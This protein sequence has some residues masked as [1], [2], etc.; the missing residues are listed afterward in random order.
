MLKFLAILGVS[1]PV[2][3]AQSGTVTSGGQPIPGVAIRATQGERAITTVSD[4]NGAFEFQNMTPGTWTVEADMFGF[5]HFKKDFEIGTSPVKIDISLQLGTVQI[6][7]AAPARGPGGRGEGRGGRGGQGNQANE[8]IAAPDLLAEAPPEVNPQIDSSTANDSFQIQGTI[9]NGLETNNRDFN[10]F[11]PGFP[12]G[13]D[14]GGPNGPGGPGGPNGQGGNFAQGGPGGPGGPGGGGRGGGGGRQGG[15]NF[16]GGGFGPGGGGGGGRGGGG[17]GGRGQQARGLIGNRSRQGANQIRV[18]VFDTISDSAFDAKNYSVNGQQSIKPST[19]SNR[20]GINIGG[21]FIIPH[22]VDWSKWL[23]FTVNYNG[24]IQQNATNQYST[25]P[26]S[27]EQQGNFSGINSIIYDPLSGNTTPFPGNQIP[28]TRLDPIALGLE[29]YIP[30]PNEPGTPGALGVI[31]NYQ[32]ILATPQNNQQVSV[33]L[34]ITVSPKDR[35]A[36]QSQTQSRDQKS[37]QA[38]GFIDHT[39]G[40]GQNQSVQ[41]THNFTARLFNTFQVGLNRNATTGT[42]YFQTLGQ[43]IEQEL[44]I[45]GFWNDPLNYGIPSVNFQNYQTLS[46]GYPSKSIVQ[47]LQAQ[48]SLSWRKGKHNLQFGGQFQRYDTNLLV[49]NSGRGSFSFTSAATALD[50]SASNGSGNDFASFLLGLPQN[51]STTWGATRYLRQNAYSMWVNDDFRF[52]STL[53]LQ[54]GVRYE[55]TSP[56]SEK[57]GEI[58]N[59]DFAQGFSGITQVVTG[60]PATTCP[61]EASGVPCNAIGGP[62]LNPQRGAVEP[63]IG[64]AWQAMKRGSLLI[65]AG[66]GTYYNGG[67]YNAV[68]RQMALAPQF[69]YSSGQ[70]ETESTNV[71]TLADGL[72]AI[73]TGKTIS[74]SFAYNPDYKIPYSQSW[75]FGIQRNL[76]GNLVMQINYTGIK[77]THLVQGLDPNQALPGDPLTASARLPIAYASTFTYDQTGGNLISNSGTASL[78]RRMRRNLAFQFS[79]TR[80]KSIDDAP[81]LALNPFDLAAERA[82]STNDRRDVVQFQ[83]TAESPVDQR[84]GFLANKGI[85]T[86]VLKNWTLQAPITWETGLPLTATVAGDI[87]GIGANTNGQRAEATGLPIFA[88]SGFFN[89]AAFAIPATGTFGN[90]GRDTIPGPDTFTLNANMSRTFTLKERKSLEIQINSTN[91]LNHPV[92]TGFGTQVNGFNYGVVSNFLGMRVISGTIRFRM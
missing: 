11:Q 62:L 61:S 16:Q 3:L 49:D 59:L 2:A 38:L 52:L 39:T 75:N 55:Y 25:V 14:F 18:N 21:P 23:N 91:P 47:T 10:G 19:M 26:T 41:Y 32:F 28:S 60:A 5:N 71:L 50:N 48:N 37:A 45:N 69:V 44:G 88:G 82:L 64:L 4:A 29:K 36:I 31:D 86:K 24:T 42:P 53:S 43:N 6:T 20:Y 73:P 74:N 70:L 33:R 79:Y 66:Y 40:F 77:G 84:N 87:A 35:L 13:G 67:I 1:L 80:A 63:R 30:L 90:A 65:R 34:Q 22:V 56:I 9:S 78:I 12:G 15:G 27:A 92:P 85:L 68:V 17:R 81:A 8:A 46:D 57:Y 7:Q 89:P 83:F 76:P 58:A 72:A 54:L 51:A